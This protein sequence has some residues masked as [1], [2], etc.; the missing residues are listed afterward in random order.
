[1]CKVKLRKKATNFFPKSDVSK[2]SCSDHTFVSTCC[3]TV[4]ESQLKPNALPLKYIA[5]SI[6][7]WVWSTRSLAHSCWNQNSQ[8]DWELET[9]LPPEQALTVTRRA[10]AWQCKKELGGNMPHFHGLWM[11]VWVWAWGDRA[12]VNEWVNDCV[13]AWMRACVRK[14]HADWVWDR[15][16]HRRR[17]TQKRRWAKKQTEKREEQKTERNRTTENRKKQNNRKQKETEQ[18]KTERN[19]KAEGGLS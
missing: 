12:S 18:Q 3:I 2:G 4:P 5:L 7:M 13:R 1:M 9:E 19:R 10:K 14:M 15:L 6:L 8:R 16:E 17:Y 11:W